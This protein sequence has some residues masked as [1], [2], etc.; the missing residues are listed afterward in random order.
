MTPR[1]RILKKKFVYLLFP[2]A[3]AFLFVDSGVYGR[4]IWGIVESRIRS[5]DL[6]LR[7]SEPSF[8][9]GT[10]SLDRLEIFH[11]SLSEPVVLEDVHAS[12]SLSSILSA[13]LVVALEANTLGGSI[14]LRLSAFSEEISGE[15]KGVQVQELPKSGVVGVQQGILDASLV[16][17]APDRTDQIFPVQELALSLREVS[18]P[19]A[20]KLPTGGFEFTIPKIPSL[21][22]ALK[23]RSSEGRI[24]VD[25]ITLS[26][27]LA[28][29]SGSG[30]ISQSA[31]H[32]IQGV[33]KGRM[34]RTGIRELGTLLNLFARTNNTL[35]RDGFALTLSG[36]IRG[37]RLK[38][39]PY[40]I[41]ESGLPS[42]EPSV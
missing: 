21:S 23:A 6:V 17:F 35:L 3:A 7:E 31:P 41:P 9:F 38:A 32:E 2:L 11:S 5:D 4:L 37:P 10:L 39:E 22:A 40:K 29:L 16:G 26:G 25:S 20:T 12:P 27:S 33:I 24:I 19:E 14:E 1:R 42:L 15:V 13:D 30:T 8:S 18:I 34:S 36:P 28:G